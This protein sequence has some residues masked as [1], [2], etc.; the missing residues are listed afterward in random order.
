MRHHK[1][2]VLVIELHITTHTPGL[3]QR[4]K[5]AH[6]IIN[7]N[8]S[9]SLKTKIT[10]KNLGPLKTTQLMCPT[11]NTLLPNFGNPNKNLFVSICSRA[12]QVAQCV[13]AETSWAGLAF[14][15][16]GGLP[17]GGPLV[18]VWGLCCQWAEKRGCW[19]SLLPGTPW[20]SRALPY[21][22]K[23]LSAILLQVPGN[24]RGSPDPWCCSGLLPGSDKG[25]AFLA[26]PGL[27]LS[28]AAIL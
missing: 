15:G 17:G 25:M 14:V 26:N 21:S 13:V 5:Q 8:S 3:T 16:P 20:V 10:I 1:P 28:H 19:L 2:T 6:V 7:L 4:T 12:L 23:E 11:Q 22:V 18:A 27:E 24:P 9:F